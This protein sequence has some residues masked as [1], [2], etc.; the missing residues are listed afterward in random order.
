MNQTPSKGFEV[1]ESAVG[2]LRGLLSAKPA[3]AGLRILVKG[4]GCS[5]L[6]YHMELADEPKPKDKVFERDGVRVFIDAKSFLYLAGTTLTWEESFMSSA[7]RLHN[8]NAKT[9][10]GCGESFSV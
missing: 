5:G 9:S 3:T 1:S 7:F 4:G 6:T 8:P 2:R 10:C